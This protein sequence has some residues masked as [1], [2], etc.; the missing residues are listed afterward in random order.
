MRTVSTAAGGHGVAWRPP[1]GAFEASPAGRMAARHGIGDWP[2][3]LQRSLQDPAWFWRAAVEDIG[4]PWMAP[5]S[6][7]LDLGDG[8]EFP[9]FFAG[10]RLNACDAAVDRWLREGR[11]QARAVHWE[12]DDGG[13]RTLTYEQLH[14]EVCRAAGALAALGVG[15]GDVVAMLLPMIPE[16]VVTLLA[17]ARIGAVVA[18]MFS[19]FGAHAV[20]MRLADS[21][22]RVLVTCDTF[23]RRGRPVRLKEV[24][25]EAMDGGADVPH[26]LVVRR[27]AGVCTMRAGR[28]AW[29]HEALGA[30]T[31]RAGAEPLDAEAPLLYLY[32]SGSTGRPK[33][34]V[35]THAGLPVKVAQESRHNL[36][37]D[38]NACTLWVTDM[39]WVMGG[40]LTF[41]T[42]LNGGTV[43]LFEGS[44]DW[45]QPDR[46]WRAVE[47]A[48]ATVLG[49]SPTLV[50]AL[51]AHGDDWPAAHEMPTLQA[52]GSTGEP[53]NPEPWLWCLHSVGRGR[54]P[55]V[56]ISGGTECG[57]ALLAG[58]TSVAAK[59]GSFAGPALGV[60]ADV[61]DAAGRSVRGDVGELVVRAPWPGMTRG[62]RD[63]RERYVETYWSA[64]PGMWRQ[65]DF[66][67]VD[68]DGFWYLLGRSDDTIMVAGKRVGPAEVESL[69][70]GDAA[71]V[72]AAA[73]G[74]HD[75]LK[76]E[77]LV[78]LVTVRDR[79]QCDEGA[80]AQ[81]LVAVVTQA[82]GRPM[83][84][85]AVH[86]V[87]ALPR[88][89]NGKVLRR[90]A[91]A[92]Y[93]GEPLGDLSA[94]ED[95][96]V[97]ERL[98]RAAGTAHP[99]E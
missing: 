47:T 98:P 20:R 3:L 16:A 11:A 31:P 65:G 89:R 22:A 45:P 54:R 79:A 81:R 36:G 13:I 58:A 23:P 91:R 49:V 90:V 5:Y 68:D 35:H 34:C 55:I 57:G 43:A 32:T 73:I 51:M 85:R 39:G 80:L 70:V 75:D 40:Y 53:W 30:A 74:V 63:G 9:H 82:L 24:A 72:E 84:P 77:A 59:P 96:S 28:D 67:V 38:E 92:V 87:D 15:P 37:I 25:D 94:L 88:T 60:A 61:V 48:G 8:V 21:G 78:C 71:V 29:W 7:V 14:A 52:I 69:L 19:G 6:S 83:A 93:T 33:A 64:F 26:V 62:F 56:N 2:A 27:G 97:L 76:G 42:L 50:R 17:A 46:L 66:A 99:G 10:G 4:I 95:A 86:V 41:G 12:G 1:P 18:P 44:P